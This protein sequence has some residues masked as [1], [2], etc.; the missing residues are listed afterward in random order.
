[1]PSEPK[2]T[3]TFVSKHFEVSRK[4]AQNE[5]EKLAILQELCFSRSKQKSRSKKELWYDE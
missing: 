1:M 5:S 2:T 3:Q 4:T